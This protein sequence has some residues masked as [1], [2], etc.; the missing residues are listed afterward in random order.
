[1]SVEI[2]ESVSVYF[3]DELTID[4]IKDLNKAFITLGI[5]CLISQE[6]DADGITLIF[7]KRC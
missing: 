5:N 4:D 1:M 6:S 7:K 3:E 2:K